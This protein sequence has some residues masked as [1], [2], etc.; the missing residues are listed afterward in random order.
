MACIRARERLLG[1]LDGVQGHG[2]AVVAVGDGGDLEAGLVGFQAELVRHLL[3]AAEAAA[4]PPVGV[5]GVGLEQRSRLSL[6]AAVDADDRRPQAE[7][8]VAVAGAHARAEYPVGRGL[9]VPLGAVDRIDV[10]VDARGEAAASAQE[11]PRVGLMLVADGGF[12]HAGDAQ[13]IQVL[14]R[15]PVAFRQLFQR[16]RCDGGEDV[17]DPAVVPHGTQGCALLVPEHRAAGRIRGVVLNAHTAQRRRVGGPAHGLALAQQH[18]VVGGDRVEVPARGVAPLAQPVVVEAP[19]HD[20]LAGGGLVHALL[21]GRCDVVDG[22][23]DLR[24][25]VDPL[26]VLHRIDDVHVVLHEPG[27]QRAPRQV[28]HAGLV[29][30]QCLHGFVGAH[31]DDAVARHCHC[32]GH[33]VPLVHR[34][35]ASVDERQVRVAPCV[36]CHERPPS[37]RPLPPLWSLIPVENARDN[38]P[39]QL[40]ARPVQP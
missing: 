29:A 9:H 10:E 2:D 5:V 8:V 11:L 23:G 3:G 40:L 22:G 35:D 39:I 15:P 26:A 18:W 6:H 1:L 30:D 32:L 36:A 13:S 24:A 28:H 4:K 12:V 20:Q 25:T 16:R 7:P 14:A 27:S 21:H 34:N 17:H 38:P 19:A 31:A 37:D 33:L